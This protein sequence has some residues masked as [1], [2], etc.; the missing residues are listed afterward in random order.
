[1]LEDG[2]AERAAAKILRLS[3]KLAGGGAEASR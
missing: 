1:V 2:D 3:E